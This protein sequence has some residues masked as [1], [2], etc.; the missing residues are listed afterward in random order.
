[1]SVR[2]EKRERFA[3]IRNFAEHTGERVD[4]VVLREQ[5]GRVHCGAIVV[6]VLELLR[7]MALQHKTLVAGDIEAA[8]EGFLD[9]ADL[10]MAR[11]NGYTFELRRKS[12]I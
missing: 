2:H 11:E 7:G 10:E 4:P 9:G 8:I 6:S 12:G 5:D 1:M 3:E